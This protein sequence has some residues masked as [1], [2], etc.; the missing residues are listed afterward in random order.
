[1][2]AEPDGGIQKIRIGRIAGAQGLRG[3][4]RLYHDSG[5]E[6][7]IRRVN[8]LFLSKDRISAE[9]RVEG[10]RMQK[11]TPILKLSGV[12]D[13]NAAE[14]LIGAEAF[15]LL[16]EARPHEEGSWLVSDLAGLDVLL[17]EK[18]GVSIGKV[19]GILDNPAHD[20][21]EIETDRGLRLLP[22]IDAFVREVDVAGG[23]VLI[24]PP[25]GWPD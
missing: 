20:L 14:A 15:V 16:D 6:E 23:R 11:R 1:M 22:F 8:V 5:D 18:G 10:L 19:R 13:R 21:L 4:V 12:G 3:E 25:E 7:A 2:S 17:A 24:T 9:Y